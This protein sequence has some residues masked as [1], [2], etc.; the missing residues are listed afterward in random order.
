MHDEDGGMSWT[1]AAHACR[2]FLCGRH[3]VKTR[4]WSERWVDVEQLLTGLATRLR[5]SRPTGTV[6]LDDGWQTDRDIRVTAGSLA[7]LDL[8]VLV[9]QHSGGRCLVRVAQCL[10][11]SGLLVATGVAGAGCLLM[12]ASAQTIEMRTIGGSVVL[13]AAA[14]ITT[15]LRRAGATLA[16]TRRVAADLAGELGM[17]ALPIEAIQPQAAAGVSTER[18]RAARL[19]DRASDPLRIDP[20]VVGGTQAPGLAMPLRRGRSLT[21]VS[22]S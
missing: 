15:A 20:E 10:Q 22:P 12:A 3:T 1:D 6:E 13:A 7:S 19:P 5:S 8:R 16:A 14:V 2:A 17:Q 18:V 9:E 4:F 21:R 11:R